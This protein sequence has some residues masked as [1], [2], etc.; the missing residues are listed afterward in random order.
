MTFKIMVDKLIG[1]INFKKMTAECFS[2]DGT[3]SIFKI[4]RTDLNKRQRPNAE[5]RFQ[6]Y[7]GVTAHEDKLKLI[8]WKDLEWLA[9]NW[10]IMIQ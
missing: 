5:K 10:R 6:S 9:W 2:S 8:N 3:L 4:K 7:Q 1:T